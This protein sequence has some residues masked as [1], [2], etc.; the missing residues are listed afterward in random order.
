MARVSLIKF[1]FII[2]LIISLYSVILGSFNIAIGSAPY[3]VFNT[4]ANGLSIL[5]DKL[6]EKGHDVKVIISTLH[7]LKRI[8]KTGTLVII[9]PTISFTLEDAL[10]IM[11]F[12]SRGGSI[13]IAD[14][15]YSANSLLEYISVV[16]SGFLQQFEF[17]ENV[18]LRAI[19]LNTSGVLMDA[20]DYYKSP[21]HPIIKRFPLVEFGFAPIFSGIKQVVTN[22]P[23]TISISVTIDYKNGTK[24]NL[25][26]P[27]PPQAS[28][29]VSSEYSWI[30][31]DLKSAIEGIATPD[32]YEWGNFQFS[33]GFILDLPTGG[34]FAL[35][36]DPDIF[37]NQLVSLRNFDNLEFAL[38]LFEWL[39]EATPS[40]IIIFDESHLSHLPSDPLFGLSIW[41][42][43]LGNLVYSWFIAPFLPIIIILLMFSLLFG[44]VPKLQKMHVRLFSKVERSPETTW[45]RLR[46]RDYLTTLNYR[47]AISALLDYFNYLIES[48]YSV[49]GKTII[50]KVEN[51]ISRRSDLM[52]YKDSI[53]NLIMKMYLVSIGEEKINREEFL[54]IVNEF[55][56]IKELF[57]Y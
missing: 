33:V 50:E 15:F 31:T 16:L 14:D 45:Y 4:K 26:A 46:L 40:N 19:K 57:E 1:L 51:V 55:K 56:K 54:Q 2:A 44:Y 21:A 3:S 48:R 37:S 28:L 11:E 49:Q 27:L 6:I 30:E 24:L 35:I 32:P 17:A 36:S 47:R 13:L 34:R 5:K 8:N 25:T 20:K 38:R 52:S 53:I 23:S 18:S 42:G 10:S 43:V 12:L 39:S 22:F 29:M 7:M 41:Y 9:G